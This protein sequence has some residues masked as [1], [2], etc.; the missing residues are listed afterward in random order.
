MRDAIT[1]A[2][3]FVITALLLGG[4]C[5]KKDDNIFIDETTVVEIYGNVSGPFTVPGAAGDGVTDDTAAIQAALDA[6]KTA[7]N[8]NVVFLPTA[9]Y[10][11]DGTIYIPAYTTLAGTYQGPG[12]RPGTTLLS[13]G[14]AG[15][16]TGEGCIVLCFGMAC[17]KNM[18]IEY[19][20]QNASNATPTP[21]PYAIS[22]GRTRGL[23]MHG[24]RIE[25]IYLYNA[26]QG[27][28]LD[29]AHANIVRNI[30][31]NPLKVG[32]NVDHCFDVSRIENVH[33]WPYF[34]NGK[35][36]ES[37]VQQNG[38]A[39]QFGR[40]DWQY[41]FNLFCYGYKTGFL[42]YRQNNI[43]PTQ[44]LPGGV[45]NGNFLGCG[46]DKGSISID[47][48]DCMPQGVSFTNGEFASFGSSSGRA[49]FLRGTNGG[50]IN[51]TNCNFWAITS[52]MAEVAGGKLTLQGCNIQEW[53]LT[54][55][56]Q[57]CFLQTAGSLTVDACTFNQNGLLGTL[58]GGT[59]RATFTSNMSPGTQ[60]ITNGIG[61]RLECANN[62]P[63]IVH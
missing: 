36:M 47:V 45:T 53:A 33:F 51:F 35:T 57:P 9:D 55:T 50:N 56:T 19:P 4:G 14:Y 59:A 25:E 11:I 6:A 41:C 26:Y 32:I 12:G 2:F 54:E 37:W 18:R 38:V 7:G 31:G 48:E 16:S 60:N 30:W 62:N 49:I 22:G 10:L 52:A 61:V 8:G 46:V 3:A 24:A 29:E 42:F 23:G 40:S 21:Y 1:V 63:A 28:D 13:T 44:S 5:E 27:I 34:V 39:F 15:T 58:S 17:I 20:N 43:S